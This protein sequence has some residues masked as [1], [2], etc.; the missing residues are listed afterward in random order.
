MP[1]GGRLLL[2]TANV[3][4][5]VPL[6]RQ[7]ATVPAGQYVKLRIQDSGTGIEAE[8]LPRIFEPFFTTK[9]KGKGTGLGLS[10]VYGIVK[11]S[12]G[13]IFVE[14]EKGMGTTF[15]IYLSRLDSHSRLAT[16]SREPLG[17]ESQERRRLEGTETILLVEDEA[18]V[19]EL[20]SLTLQ[21]KGYH[22][23]VAEDGEQ[24]LRLWQQHRDEIDLIVTDVVMP[25]LSGRELVKRT[26]PEKPELRVLFLSGYTD[27]AVGH[28]AI[29]DSNLSFMSK[30]FTPS[31]LAAKVRDVLDQRRRSP[32]PPT[33]DPTG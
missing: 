29:P 12:N 2:E 19:R 27:E 6:E 32:L 28:P 23:L 11:Q 14:S 10:T 8:I 17:D 21:M 7:G 5:P 15:D 13:F 33:T 25:H 26:L 18:A 24:G 16:T 1:L 4:L 9:E 31:S 20:A 30:P 3:D 22:L